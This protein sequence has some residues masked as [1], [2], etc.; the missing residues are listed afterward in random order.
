[1]LY[2][3]VAVLRR[4]SSRRPAPF[5]D[6]RVGVQ[7]ADD[8]GAGGGAGG[9]GADGVD[10]VRRGVRGGEACIMLSS[11]DGC[12]YCG[13]EKEARE[14]CMRAEL[15]P[16]DEAAVVGCGVIPHLALVFFT[17]NGQVMGYVYGGWILAR[18]RIQ[19]LIG[20]SR[21]DKVFSSVYLLYGYKSTNTDA[22]QR[23]ASSSATCCASTAAIPSLPPPPK[24]L[25][26]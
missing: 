15:G 19:G 24:L 21:S 20:L 25:L 10:E 4:N 17:L 7:A 22:L 6:F 13:N 26:P 8:A 1:M 2:F 5:A 16:V 3:E 14:L 9:G 23:L 18:E 12:V 11:V